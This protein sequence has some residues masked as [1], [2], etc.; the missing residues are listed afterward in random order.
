MADCCASTIKLSEFF[1]RCQRWKFMLENCIWTRWGWYAWHSPI[2]L[3]FWDK[4]NFYVHQVHCS[5]ILFLLCQILMVIF[6]VHHQQ[7]RVWSTVQVALVKVWSLAKGECRMIKKLWLLYGV[8]LLKCADLI[9]LRTF[10][11]EGGCHQFVWSKVAVPLL[12]ILLHHICLQLCH[13]CEYRYLITFFSSIQCMTLATHVS[14][15][16]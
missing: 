10:W 3:V 9:P 16:L 6:V 8:K 4:A 1:S 2:L 7:V 13:L 14:H 15:F 5:G 11:E 12:Y